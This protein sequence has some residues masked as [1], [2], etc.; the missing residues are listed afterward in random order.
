VPVTWASKVDL[1][2]G[3][4]VENPGVRY[5]QGKGVSL[6]PSPL[7]AHNWLPMAFSPKS[8]LVYIPAVDFKVTFSEPAPTWKPST[9][10]NTDAGA[11]MIGGPLIG[12]KPPTG[13]LIAL[14]PVTQ[15][16]VWRVDYP[17]YVNGGVLATGGDLVFQG[18]IDGLFK[19]FSATDGKVLWS[20]DTR[21][22]MIAPAIT[23]KAGGKQYVTLLTG[24]G[25]AYPKNLGALG[26]PD[27]ERWGLDPRTQARRV[28]TFV[29]GGKGTLPPRPVAPPPPAD[30]TFTVD[31]ARFMPGAMAFTAHCGDCHG[32]LA[33]GSIQAPD[34]RRSAVPQ[35]RDAFVQIVRGGVLQ[36]QGMPK[37]GELDDK[38]L[39]DIRYYVRARA[40]QLRGQTAPATSK[41]PTKLELK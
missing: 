31:Q 15:K 29:I 8:G 23:Y 10:R 14:N 24:L 7:A 38:T 18:T 39:D 32:S 27:V 35:D 6:S 22:P 41:G 9:D 13:A 20:F 25:M 28:L 3:R 19:A 4:P 40:A 37:F 5:D 30:P 16:P 2:T 33:V 34:L 11:N 17:T 12:E 1:A 26:G 21:A 36:P